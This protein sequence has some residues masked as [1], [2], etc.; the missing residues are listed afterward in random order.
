MEKDIE[1]S[2]PNCVS[3][4]HARPSGGCCGFCGRMGFWHPTELG[5][6][7]G[8]KPMTGIEDAIETLGVCL[9][10]NRSAESGNVEPVEL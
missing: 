8:T 5:I 2:G 3:L 1:K 6:L 9:A 7:M 10:F 4:E